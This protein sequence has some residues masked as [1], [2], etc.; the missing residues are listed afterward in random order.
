MH[1]AMRRLR[2]YQQAVN[3]ALVVGW[4]NQVATYYA[5]D[6]KLV[7][8]MRQ[9][10]ELQRQAMNG[11]LCVGADLAGAGKDHTI[12]QFWY[13]S[14]RGEADSFELGNGAEAR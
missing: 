9:T 7:D 10:M 6:A 3:P 11:Q 12:T 13:M 2:A 1:Y 4:R 14:R 5:P 8:N